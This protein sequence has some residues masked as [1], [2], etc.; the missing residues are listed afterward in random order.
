M[1]GLQEVVNKMNDWVKKR[2][3]KVNVGKTKVMV[4]ERGDSTTECDVLIEVKAGYGR[5]KI[6]AGST[7]WRCDRCVVCAK[8]FGKINVETVSQRAARQGVDALPRSASFRCAEHNSKKAD[9][10]CSGRGRCDKAV[11]GFVTV[12][13]V[14]NRNYPGSCTQVRLTSTHVFSSP[15]PNVEADLYRRE[16]TYSYPDETAHSVLERALKPSITDV[17]KASTAVIIDSPR[18]RIAQRKE[19]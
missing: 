3:R 15:E 14:I 2:G 13:W 8:G 16:Q 1:C 5:R 19:L 12:K 6:K 4:F 17:V 7:W 9:R 11:T 10:H 18:T